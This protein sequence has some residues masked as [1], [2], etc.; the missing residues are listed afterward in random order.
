MYVAGWRSVVVLCWFSSGDGMAGRINDSQQGSELARGSCQAVRALWDR[1][2]GVRSASHGEGLGR[3]AE[4]KCRGRV[5]IEGETAQTGI[6]GWREGSW[7]RVR[8]LTG[9]TSPHAP[10]PIPTG[11]YLSHVPCPMRRPCRSTMVGDLVTF[12][13]AVV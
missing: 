3:D 10:C 8:R 5:R 4:G 7:R 1:L 6:R 11:R 13:Y 9:G 2:H 12:N